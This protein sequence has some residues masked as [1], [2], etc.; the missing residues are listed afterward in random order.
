MRAV[1]RIVLGLVL[2][3]EV[4]G[5]ENIPA[6]GATVLMM[7]HI[8][9]LDPI[10]CLAVI[11]HRFVVPMS[12]IENLR[13]PIVGPMVRA[14][15]AYTINRDEVDRKALMSSIEL[16]KSGEL[17][18]IAPEGTR[19]KEGLARPKEGFAFVVTKA[20]A[21]IVPAAISGA[22]GWQKKLMRLQRPHV[23]VNFGRP[24]KF[25]TDGRVPRDLL[26]VL[27][28]EAMYQ[29][30]AAVTDETMRG[31]YSDLHNASTEHLVLL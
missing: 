27:M 12:K 7:N 28:D 25:K 30:S 19:Q 17:I 31:V 24:F 15:G 10:L 8:S 16:L 20:D 13:N 26:P 22:I 3:L 1:A 18:L 11:K 4:R 9:L 29:L 21:V 2:K 23:T 5:V 6:D 14:W